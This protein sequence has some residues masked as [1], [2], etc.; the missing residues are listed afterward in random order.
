M[1]DRPENL[2]LAGLGIAVGKYASSSVGTVSCS[3][4]E[5]NTKV[6]GNTNRRMSDYF[7]VPDGIELEPSSRT[8]NVPAGTPNTAAHTQSFTYKFRE[9]G[10]LFV[11]IKTQLGNFH[12]DTPPYDEGWTGSNDHF[13]PFWN[14]G[15]GGHAGWQDWTCMT[16]ASRPGNST[17][18][19]AVLTASFKDNFIVTASFQTQSADIT[20]V[21][22]EGG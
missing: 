9:E 20:V 19:T 3:L 12:G 16:T 22:F 7:A 15:S 18:R 21:R 6:F 17:P 8:F 11:N 13:S 14:S 2:S 5:C 1:P 10:P 4:T